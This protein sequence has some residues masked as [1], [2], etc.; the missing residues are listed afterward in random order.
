VRRRP[1]YASIASTLALFL[2]IGGGS[3]WA[4][5][6]HHYLITSTSQIK[7][8]VVRK[9]RGHN[10][11]NGAAGARG[12]NGATGATGVTGATGATGVAGIVIGSNGST[13]LSAI[14][15]AIVESTAPSSGTFL[16]TG[17]VS[18]AETNPQVD[19]ALSCSIVD[20]TKAP[21]TDLA[22]SSATF[23]KETTA[24]S[25]VDVTVQASATATSGDTIAI[26]CV[27]GAAGY[28]SPQSAITLIP[29][30]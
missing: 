6:H 21:G 29:E 12:A 10:G 20:I 18:G 8:K 7:P 22:T 13:S 24:S 9:L 1:S 17:Q 25:F 15:S 14:T 5:T 30:H 28:S 27:A 23:P 4:V 26:E 3:A 19:G 11:A 16:V 2:V